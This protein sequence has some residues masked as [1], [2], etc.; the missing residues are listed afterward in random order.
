[1]R[2]RLVES[3]FW[4]VGMFESHQHG[5]QRK[6]A[7]TIIVLATVIDDIYDVYGTLDELELFTDTFKRLVYLHIYIYI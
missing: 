4:A 5:Y 7:A 1:M 3:F 6:M 2:D